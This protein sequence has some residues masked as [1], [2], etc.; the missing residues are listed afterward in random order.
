MIKNLSDLFSFQSNN[1]IANIDCF[2][3]L[4]TYDLFNLTQAQSMDSFFSRL[5]FIGSCHSLGMGNILSWQFEG[6]KLDDNKPLQRFIHNVVEGVALNLIFLS[7]AQ[8][9]SGQSNPPNILLGSFVVSI[10]L[11]GTSSSLNYLSHKT[12]YLE[13][14]TE[15]ID[16][17]LGKLMNLIARISSV[18][19]LLL[20]AS[21]AKQS[22]IM[23]GLTCL[24][25]G[26]NLLNHHL[27]H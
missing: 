23:F 19:T 1:K 3:T 13:N 7:A 26:G 8:Y 21:D 9:L 10:M 20:I 6:L 17:N 2:K 18:I 27:N 15:T 14:A 4:L 5:I 11:A 24:A 22:P 12:H 25:V 16:R